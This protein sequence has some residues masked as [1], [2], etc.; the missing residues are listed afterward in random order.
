MSEIQIRPG[1]ICAI[2]W[3]GSSCALDWCILKRLE[4]CFIGK[5]SF[6][7]SGNVEMNIWLCCFCYS[8]FFSRPC[9]ACVEPVVWACN[10]GGSLV[11]LPLRLGLSLLS[12]SFIFPVVKLLWRFL[13]WK[14]TGE[15]RWVRKIIPNALFNLLGIVAPLPPDYPRLV[16][17]HLFNLDVRGNVKINI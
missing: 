15:T 3:M 7:C 1:G 12:S 13:L 8:S 17:S 16:F 2:A 6:F 10:I 14:S 9:V 11:G 5:L 4:L